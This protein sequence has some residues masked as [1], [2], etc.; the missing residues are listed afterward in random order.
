MIEDNYEY[1]I[2]EDLQYEDSYIYTEKK[3]VK[4]IFENEISEPEIM[5][6][7][8]GDSKSSELLILYAKL[9]KL[10]EYDKIIEHK[11]SFDD[12]PDS[13]VKSVYV[14]NFYMVKKI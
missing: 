1:K 10:H 13:D 6:F 8:K 7:C 9:A 3:C 12:N 4:E 14:R 5:L 2:N 11:V